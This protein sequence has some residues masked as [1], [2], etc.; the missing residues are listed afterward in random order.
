MH[1]LG[2][3]EVDGVRKKTRC[4]CWRGGGPAARLSK[5]LGMRGKGLVSHLGV[6]GEAVASGALDRWSPSLLLYRGRA[7]GDLISGVVGCD[8]DATRGLE[9]VDRSSIVPV[10][11]R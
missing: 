5:K 3:R 6:G 1:R 8:G 9:V 4:L 2:K 10:P 7:V 11:C